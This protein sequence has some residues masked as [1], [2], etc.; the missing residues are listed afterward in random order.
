MTR[1]QA[2]KAL[3]A[4]LDAGQ[5]LDKAAR[6][7]IDAS[8]PKPTRYRTKRP[9]SDSQR[10][11]YEA[12]TGHASGYWKDYFARMDALSKPPRIRLASMRLTSWG[13]PPFQP[14]FGISRIAA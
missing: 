10:R 8:K 2:L 3:E 13:P 11:M 14:R 9:L 1:G 6:D 7:L 5:G 4:A 12:G